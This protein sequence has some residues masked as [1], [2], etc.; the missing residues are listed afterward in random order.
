MTQNL[1]AISTEFSRSRPNSTGIDRGPKIFGSAWASAPSGGGLVVTL[2][3]RP[4]PDTGL[5]VEFDR[6]RSNAIDM[7]IYGGPPEKWILRV[8]PFKVTE[9]HRKW[10]GSIGYL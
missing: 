8:T 5:H 1:A 3:T 9:S 7:R 10:H 4:I 6:C 2:E